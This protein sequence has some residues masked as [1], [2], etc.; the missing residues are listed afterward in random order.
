MYHKNGPCTRPVWGRGAGMVRSRHMCSM[1]TDIPSHVALAIVI[2]GVKK[3]P[4]VIMDMNKVDKEPVE[5][6]YTLLHKWAHI[7]GLELVYII[8]KNDGMTACSLCTC[9]FVARRFETMGPRTDLLGLVLNGYRI[10]GR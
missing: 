5:S 9:L 8:D 3:M 2:A 6:L 7:Y 1:I 10:A 4:L